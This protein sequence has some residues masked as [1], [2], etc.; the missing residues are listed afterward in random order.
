MEVSERIRTAVQR[1]LELQ[2]YEF[3]D[4]IGHPCTGGRHE[5]ICRAVDGET[6]DMVL[7]HVVVSDRMFLDSCDYGLTV[8]EFD[9]CLMEIVS[10]ENIPIG[11]LRYDFLNVNKV[12][13]DRAFIKHHVKAPFKHRLD[14]E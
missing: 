2:G 11:L 1:Y 14:E 8:D 9:K 5:S 4:W 13:D 6:E 12:G 10:Y 3:I 7:I